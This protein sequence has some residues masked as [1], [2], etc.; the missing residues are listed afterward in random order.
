MHKITIDF[1]FHRINDDYDDEDVMD[2]DNVIKN[3]WKCD[4]NEKGVNSSN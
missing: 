3:E 1:Q 4:G 2:V